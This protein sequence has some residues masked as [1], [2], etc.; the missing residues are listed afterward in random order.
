MKWNLQHTAFVSTQHMPLYSAY[1]CED[2]HCIGN[3]AEHC[4]ACA[5]EALMS[6]AGV[7]NRGEPKERAPMTYPQMDTRPSI[8]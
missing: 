6:L 3:S 7:L 5:S 8:V 2:C 1:L 4:P